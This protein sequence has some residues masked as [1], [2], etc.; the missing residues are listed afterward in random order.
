MRLLQLR[1]RG[2]DDSSVSRTKLERK[3]KTL[4]LRGQVLWVLGGTGVLG[5]RFVLV[6]NILVLVSSKSE[7]GDKTPLPG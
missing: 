3:D 1:Q 7:R 5:I 2:R 4:L 6:I